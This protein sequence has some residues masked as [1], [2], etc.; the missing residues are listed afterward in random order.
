MILRIDEHLEHGKVVQAMLIMERE[1]E[2]DACFVVGRVLNCI[3]LGS[4]IFL[5][6]VIFLIYNLCYLCKFPIKVKGIIQ[7]SPRQ[8]TLLLL[9][10]PFLLDYAQKKY[11]NYE[12]KTH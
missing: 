2:R 7:L 8:T 3:N 11:L 5:K 4:K 1:R 6:L 10:S 9:P 12:D